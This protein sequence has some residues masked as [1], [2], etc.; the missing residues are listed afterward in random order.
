MC[1]DR[2]TVICNQ[3]NF[4]LHGNAYKIKQALPNCHIIFK[5]ARKATLDNGRPANGMFIALPDAYRSCIK[6]VSPSHWRL[7]AAI[8]KSGS[9]DILIINSYFPTDNGLLQINENEFG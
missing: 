2:I 5:E 7:Q 4:L 3:E 8:L 6:D 1:G 9:R